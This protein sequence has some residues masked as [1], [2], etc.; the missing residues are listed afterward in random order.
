MCK[1]ARMLDDRTMHLLNSKGTLSHIRTARTI[2]IKT[3][4]LVSR[5]GRHFVIIVKE[6][7]KMSET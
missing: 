6:S 1:P 2:K 7:Y 5:Q 4:L 3:D